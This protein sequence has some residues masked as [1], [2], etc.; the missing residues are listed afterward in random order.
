MIIGLYHLTTE[1]G[2]AAGD[3]RAFSSVAEAIMAFDARELDLS[4]R[5]RIRLD[6][7]VPSAGC[8]LP[9]MPRLASPASSVADVET[10]LGRAL[11]NE[12]LPAGLPVRRRAGRQEARCR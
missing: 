6:D 11:F 8:V 12:T 1:R 2:G 3:G 7:V 9:R 10:T 4:S 5:V